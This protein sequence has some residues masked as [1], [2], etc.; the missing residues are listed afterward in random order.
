L[1]GWMSQTVGPR[2]TLMMAGTVTTA[3][4]FAA[5]IALSRRLQVP[6]PSAGRARELLGGVRAS[7]ASRRLAVSGRLGGVRASAASGRLAVS[8][9]LADSRRLLARRLVAP[10]RALSGHLAA[11]PGQRSDRSTGPRVAIRP[12]A[13]AAL[14]PAGSVPVIEPAPVLREE[15][16]APLVRQRARIGSATRV[17]RPAT[18]YPP[19]P[20]VATASGVTRSGSVAAP[21]SASFG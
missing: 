13:H 11:V 4:C 18:A 20:G 3:A 21:G 1:L 14:R 8:G 10:G 9:R 12:V 16:A 5:A 19:G 17:A 7:A 2:A 15:T 6:L